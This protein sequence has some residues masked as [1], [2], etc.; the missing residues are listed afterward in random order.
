MVAKHGFRFLACPSTLAE[1]TIVT[2]VFKHSYLLIQSRAAPRNAMSG[3]LNEDMKE[4]CIKVN[5]FGEQNSRFCLFAQMNA[6]SLS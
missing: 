6:L 2:G 5:R 4:V 1:L 3:Q